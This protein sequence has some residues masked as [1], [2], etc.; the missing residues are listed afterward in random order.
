MPKVTD[1]GAELEAQALVGRG[2]TLTLNA[3]YLKAEFGTTVVDPSGG[4]NVVDQGDPLTHAPRFTLRG[5][6]EQRFEL[7]DAGSLRAKLDAR[8]TDDQWVNLGKRDPDNLQESY[9]T[10]D[11]ALAFEAP[12]DRWSL[13]AYVKNLNDKVVK[14]AAFGPPFPNAGD[15]GVSDPRTYGISLSAKL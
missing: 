4:P 8:Y 6:V 1:Y 14:T 2:T 12:Q 10:A 5:G 3:T 7:G 9:V 15:Y 13:S 11:F